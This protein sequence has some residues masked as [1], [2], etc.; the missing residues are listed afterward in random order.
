MSP[1]AP[2]ASGKLQALVMVHLGKLLGKVMEGG[3]LGVLELWL[4]SCVLAQVYGLDAM[5]TLLH[6]GLGLCFP[7]SVLPSKRIV[8]RFYVCETNALY[9]A[10]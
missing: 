8:L 4:L 10:L 2:A 7:I 6:L 1:K 9:G 5:H 3:F